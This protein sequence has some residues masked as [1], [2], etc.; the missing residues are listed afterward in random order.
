MGANLII[1]M[2]Y[3]IGKSDNNALLKSDKTES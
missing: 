3:F 2:F 1:D